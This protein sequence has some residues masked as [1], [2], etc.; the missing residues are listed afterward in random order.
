[1][2][3]FYNFSLKHLLFKTFYSQRENIYVLSK[4]TINLFFVGSN[5]KHFHLTN[6]KSTFKQD[7]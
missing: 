7:V 1:M 5:Q 4:A 2:K 6:E 3:N